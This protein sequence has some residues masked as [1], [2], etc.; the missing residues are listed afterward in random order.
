MASLL[1]LTQQG[2]V[3]TITDES[4][5]A[6]V[7]LMTPREL[8]NLWERQNWS[9]HEIDFTR[10]RRDWEAMEPEV[11]DQ[12]SWGLASFFV[13][14]ERVATQFGGLVMA[15]E[16]Q[17]EEAYLTTQQVDE[18]RHAQ[19]FNNLWEQ[20]LQHDGTFEE[21]LEDCR[22][23]LNDDYF[24]LF[25]GLLV[26]ANQALIENPRDVEAKVD[27]VVTYHMVIEGTLALT[28]QTS[29]P[30]G[31][32]RAGCCPGTSRGSGA[33]P[34]TSTATSPTARGSCSRRRRTPRSPGASR[35][36]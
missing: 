30:R 22:R 21:R 7:K 12:I 15:Y 6:S 35:T 3:A 2:D 9:S 18:A 19:H 20:V 29:R 36:G 24:R 10:D 4:K 25:D 5:L 27:F 1:D 16:D 26:E 28:G 33:S 34:R 8:Y 14:E 32:R 31:W 13:G 17:H 11:R 23:C